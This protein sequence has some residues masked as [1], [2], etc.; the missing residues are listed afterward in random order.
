MTEIVVSKTVELSKAGELDPERLRLDTLAELQPAMFATTRWR[1]QHQH[2]RSA[3][4]WLQQLRRRS[5]L[6]RQRQVSCTPSRMPLVR[7]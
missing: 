1:R 7:F 2:S 5:D 3:L 6:A 4:F